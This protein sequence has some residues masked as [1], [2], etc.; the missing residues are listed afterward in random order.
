MIHVKTLFLTKKDKSESYGTIEAEKNHAP[1]D[2]VLKQKDKDWETT[3][4]KAKEKADEN[5]LEVVEDTFQN[6]IVQLKLL[7]LSFEVN[8]LAP[9]NK[10]QYGCICD[11]MDN[12]KLIKLSLMDKGPEKADSV[13]QDVVKA[14]E[15]GFP[16]VGKAVE[17]P[18]GQVNEVFEEV[19]NDGGGGN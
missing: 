18:K 3:L 6:L 7:N 2:E 4:A 15:D 19:V 9:L 11:T 10:V 16:E 14:V 17:D 13:E 1:L 8:V 12:D 5:M